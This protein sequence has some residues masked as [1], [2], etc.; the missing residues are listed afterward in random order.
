MDTFP[1]FYVHWQTPPAAWT[2]GAVVWYAA[3]V[4]RVQIAYRYADGSRTYA[5]CPVEKGDH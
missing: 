1:P 2:D 5:L 3:G 4:Y